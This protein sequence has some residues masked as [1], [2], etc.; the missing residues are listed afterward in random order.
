[1]KSGRMRWKGNYSTLGRD[2]KCTRI[3]AGKPERKKSPGRHR[4]KW[5]YKVE[6]VL[7]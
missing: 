1:M 5:E 6:M 7:K 2:E 4:W 3:S